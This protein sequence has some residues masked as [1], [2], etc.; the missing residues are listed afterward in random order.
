VVLEALESP[1]YAEF[2][3][4]MHGLADRFERAPLAEAVA[5]ADE[6]LELS[7]RYSELR[8]EGEERLRKAESFRLLANLAG[9]RAAGSPKW[10]GL[11]DRAIVAHRAILGNV[12]A[13]Y[14][15]DW[16]FTSQDG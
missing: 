11:L 9:S 15:A 8:G 12:N 7:A 16:M 1:E 2:A 13:T 14:L 5:I 6:A 10:R 4:A 3:A